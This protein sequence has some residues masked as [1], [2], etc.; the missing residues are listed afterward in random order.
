MYVYCRGKYQ[1]AKDISN[2][3]PVSQYWDSSEPRLIVCEVKRI[4]GTVAIKGS[5]LQEVCPSLLSA[6]SCVGKRVI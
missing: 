1:A 3:F 4:P 6:I 2:R 5:M